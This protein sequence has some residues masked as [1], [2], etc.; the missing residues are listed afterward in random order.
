MPTTTQTQ[1]Q[2]SQTTNNNTNINDEFLQWWIDKAGV[3]A[4]DESKGFYRTD[5]M[6]DYDY[7]IG[8]NLYT[9]YQNK[10]NLE[11]EYLTAQEQLK[12]QTAQ[13][14]AQSYAEKVLMQKYLPELLNVQGYSGNVGLTEDAVLGLNRNYNNSLNTI[15]SNY[16]DDLNEL[17]NDYN[18][19]RLS[20]D[21]SVNDRNDSIYD[22]IKAEE[23]QEQLNW[24]NNLQSNIADMLVEDEV[25]YDEVTQ[26]LEKYKD[27]LS[28]SQYEMLKDNIENQ[29]NREEK[30]HAQSNYEGFINGQNSILTPD[31]KEILISNDN[32]PMTSKDINNII[33]AIDATFFTEMLNSPNEELQKMGYT[34][35]FDKS[36]K[37]G[38][39]IEL[40]YSF[41][42]G[43]KEIIPITYINGNW[44]MVE[45]L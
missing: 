32:T 11:K 21:N 13:A 17:T 10:Q 1:E 20:I 42:K 38:T 8:K 30:N 34:G 36:I 22:L 35:L 23:E 7:R 18:A 6:S 25:D 14:Q 39:T 12:K 5:A 41:K 26:Y 43:Q 33:K 9:G 40:K 24:Y 29:Q 28:Q 37:N 2:T 4:F 44:Y 19:N 15:Q 31:G 27:K 45:Y 3:G 16:Q